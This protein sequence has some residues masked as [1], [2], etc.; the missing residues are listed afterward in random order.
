[1]GGSLSEPPLTGVEGELKARPVDGGR[2]NGISCT[3]LFSCIAEGRFLLA[4]D[5]RVGSG[6]L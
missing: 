6:S 1:M 5:P 2:G 4:T 3:F